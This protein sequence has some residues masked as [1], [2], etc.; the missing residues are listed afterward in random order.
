MPVCSLSY[1]RT[2]PNRDMLSVSHVTVSETLCDVASVHEARRPHASAPTSAAPDSTADA[3]DGHSYEKD[4][5]YQYKS[6]I[7]VHTCNARFVGEPPPVAPFRFNNVADLRDDNNSIFIYF[8][9]KIDKM[10]LSASL[11]AVID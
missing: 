4:A 1:I 3:D 7:R 8:N 5:T 11:E 2:L 9:N 10:I 6:L